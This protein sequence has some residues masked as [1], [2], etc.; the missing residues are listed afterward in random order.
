MANS[1]FVTLRNRDIRVRILPSL[2]TR[3]WRP[4]ST[5]ITPQL[6]KNFTALTR[7]NL[8]NLVTKIMNIAT[9]ICSNRA[10]TQR[11]P[12]APW[13][14]LPYLE[15]NQ[16]DSSGLLKK[17][18]RTLNGLN[19]I[20]PQ[21]LKILTGN[22]RQLNEQKAKVIKALPNHQFTDLIA[23]SEVKQTKP[24]ES[25]RKTHSIAHNIKIEGRGGVATLARSKLLEV[26][27]YSAIQDAL[28]QT[29]ES[30][31]TTIITAIAYLSSSHTLNVTDRKHRLRNIIEQID[32]Q[33]ENYEDPSIILTGD[34]N[35]ELEHVKEVLQ[36]TST[37][38]YKDGL[39]M[40]DNYSSPLGSLFTRTGINKNG[41]VVTSRID[42]IITNTNSYIQTSFHRE[43][44]DHIL[45][46]IN[47]TPKTTKRRRVLLYHRSN[48]FKEL[49]RNRNNT[50]SDMLDYLRNNLHNFVK[51][52][53]NLTLTKDEID[54]NIP[55]DILKLIKEWIEDFKVFS[56]EISEK[57]FS[58]E[59]GTAFRTL[60]N[61]TKYDQF[62]KRDGS[63][64]TSIRMN[65]E[66]ITSDPSKVNRALL[67]VLRDN[68]QFLDTI[69]TPLNLRQ[70]L[71]RLP[72]IDT[73]NLTLLMEEISS[74]KAMTS[75]PVPDELCKWAI[76]RKKPYLLELVD[77]ERVNK[78]TRIWSRTFIK[79]NPEI[80]KCKLVPLNKAHPKVPLPK[81]MRPIVVTNV[82]YKLIE[83]RFNKPLHD[84][85][86]K[87]PEAG[88]AQFGFLRGMTCQAQ[89]QRMLE[90]IVEG[91]V[92]DMDS[93]VWHKSNPAPPNTISKGRYGLFIDFEQAF[94][95]INRQK[96]YQQ[97]ETDRILPKADLIFLFTII[98]K[99]EIHL[100][101]EVFKPKHGVPQGGITSPI[102][103]NFAIY[104]MLKE[105]LGKLNSHTNLYNTGTYITH[106]DL[107]LWADDLLIVM[108][109]FKQ[110]VISSKVL[111][112]TLSTLKET[113]LE[114]GLRINWA[115][116][117]IVPFFT[118]QR[119]FSAYRY[120]QNTDK[121]S[122]W[123][124]AKG[125]T[126]TVNLLTNEEIELPLA[127]T[128]KYLGIKIDRNL[129]G[130]PHL[131]FMKK[132]INYIMNSFFAV[133]QASMS[134]RFCYNTWQVFVRPLLDYTA[135][136]RFY[137]P[138]EDDDHYKI[139]Y[140]MTVKYMLFLPKNTM[141]YI[142][143][144]MISYDYE[145]LV[146]KMRD[147][148]FL[149]IEARL[150]DDPETPALCDKINFDYLRSE[151]K[152]IPH[153]WR[154]TVALYHK[155]GKCHLDGETLDPNHIIEHIFR[156]DPDT[157]NKVTLNNSR[158][159]IEFFLLFLNKSTRE[160][161]PLEDLYS[162]YLVLATI[163]AY[164][165]MYPDD[166]Q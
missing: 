78:F 116:S 46:L 40:C 112:T 101:D 100:G 12:Y 5:G 19:K 17:K 48:I 122:N 24:L 8:R 10:N 111:S 65:D 43:I 142:A 132:K 141:D 157:H 25:F 106:D 113:G 110:K 152:D 38:I 98:S 102:L 158:S 41:Q 143:N 4:T 94:N 160:K 86:W 125:T 90:R 85:F 117:A 21:P 137:I 2:A 146:L 13:I 129:R 108:D 28:I 57:R 59:Q 15:K 11:L 76:E 51:Y 50:L 58:I 131:N 145:D 69:N 151:W 27:S 73:K 166:Q 154:I 23:L 14:Y 67:D 139:L 165:T 33:A 29:W 118:N 115:K 155:R 55:T 45:F 93:G 22:I 144:R 3:R 63:I 128:Y 39:K 35:L 74:H 6:K 162:L 77:P 83:S 159:Y 133:R 79:E 1:L 66:T 149:K 82:I 61:I 62:M 36:D 99:L 150:G 18:I 103:F 32:V 81:Q 47:L 127:P 134:N 109:F 97:M 80:F 72:P 148:N 56:K 130:A 114:W 126:L 37:I 88:K 49:I 121:S 70:I 136:Y 161:K 75:F 104:Y 16:Y 156:M 53:D 44:S 92:Q 7:Q 123:D 54:F 84:A 135:T 34:F 89:I 31:G 138:K 26:N 96:L 52:T 140:R 120:L 9:A 124:K 68:E 147:I 95:S 164:N 64:I 107:G 20:K 153:H 87:L 91:Y 163:F 71:P 42:Y 30:R 105:F 60:K 119:S